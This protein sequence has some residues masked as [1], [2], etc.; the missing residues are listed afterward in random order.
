MASLMALTSLPML[1]LMLTLPQ[2]PLTEAFVMPQTTTKT[3]SLHQ[4]HRQLPQ[5]PPHQRQQ[6]PIMTHPSSHTTVSLSA[7]PDPSS[8]SV[9]SL[10]DTQ[11]IMTYLVQT[12]IS[13]GVPTICAILVVGFAAN[14]FRSARGKDGVGGDRQLRGQPA[15]A[16]S[17][18]Y[19]DLYGSYSS[20]SGAGGAGGARGLFGFLGGGS[21]STN[22]NINNKG[23]SINPG[24]PS[25]QYFKVT[26]L[27]EKY[28][29]YQ[30][31]LVQATQSKSLAAAQFRSQN[32]DRALHQSVLTMMGDTTATAAA[33]ATATDVSTTTLQN[34]EKTTLLE[35]E[36]SFLKEGAELMN[37]LV[38]IQTKLTDALI[39]EQMKEMN[40]DVNELDP[41]PMM[42]SNNE[43]NVANTAAS[44]S[45]SSSSNT[46]KMETARGKRLRKDGDKKKKKKSNPL[47]AEYKSELEKLQSD[48]VDLEMGFI[49]DLIYALGPDRANA[50][51]AA[52]LGDISTRG[53]G[54]LLMKL[55][56]RPLSVVLGGVATTTHDDASSSSSSS[57]STTI[58]SKP[59]LFVMDF[60]GDVQ[61]SQ[62]DD[63]REEVTAI[64]RTAT[65][66]VDE[67]LLVLQSGGGT[68]TGY[69]LAAGQLQRFRAA[70]IKLTICV[71]QVAASGGYMM[72]CTADKI[73]ASPFAVLGSIGVIT[74]IPNVYER[75]KDEG[76]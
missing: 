68:V 14:S 34:F 36:E 27:N 17:E 49:Q 9:S 58:T 61:A 29:S 35:A 21:S 1:M 50:V 42:V 37:Q 32:F 8:S 55:Q 22:N 70:G 53:V 26:H 10:L 48:L 6:H 65:P 46:E 3:N 19:Q 72:A 12:L 64:L 76:M 52:L 69:G 44:S 51:R 59:S 45:S 40:V 67:A 13:Y 18:L 24:V 56:D 75:L 43:T 62:V 30:Y 74:D 60:P 16:V 38:V 54:Q 11:A 20:S 7:L 41:E 47:I 2:L 5:Q 4:R 63:L 28:D 57:S 66:G 71:E 23:P 15:S 33:A 25:K 31:S 73:I 39:V